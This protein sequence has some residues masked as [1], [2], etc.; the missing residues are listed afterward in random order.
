MKNLPTHQ[1]SLSFRLL[2]HLPARNKI[3]QQA[4]A[5]A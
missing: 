3:A 4:K 2:F 5:L 1:L